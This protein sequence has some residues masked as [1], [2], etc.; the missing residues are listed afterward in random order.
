MWGGAAVPTRA[1]APQRAGAGRAAPAGPEP[2]V[3]GPGEGQAP[4]AH[5]PGAHFGGFV[6]FWGKSK[7]WRKMKF[8]AWAVA[9]KLA[10]KL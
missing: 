7:S 8:L 9:D 10:D 1:E 2:F 4:A 3:W 5:P 6:D